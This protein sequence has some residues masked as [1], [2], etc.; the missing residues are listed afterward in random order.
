M[1]AWIIIIILVLLGI[2]ALQIGKVNEISSKLRGEDIVERENN[3]R[4]GFWLMVFLVAFLA[5]CFWSAYHYKNV[6]LGYGPLES[7]SEHG[8]LID[9]M[10]NVTLIFTGIVFV[11]TQILTFWYAYRYRRQEGVP[12]KFISHNNTLEL[13][14]TLVPSIVLT[15][16]VV[17]GLVAW[18]SIMPDVEEDENYIEVEATGYQFAWDLRLPGPDGKLGA[19]D[20]RLIN[21]ATNPLGLDWTDENA[22]D[23]IILGGADK[24]LLPKDTMVRVSIGSKDVLHNFFLPHFRVKMD[25]VPGMPT[26]FKFRPK[27]TTEE[28]RNKLSPYPEWNELSDPSD[29][30]SLPRWKAFNFELACAELCGKGHYSMKRIIEIVNPDV[31]ENWLSQQKSYFF[32]NVRGTEADPYTDKLFD[33]EIEQRAQELSTAINEALEA[34]DMTEQVISLD[35]VF[36]ETASAN[37]SE[38]SQ[39]ELDNLASIMK[40]NPGMTIEFRGHTDNV[41]DAESNMTLS[42]NRA[43]NVKSYLVGKGIEA[44]RMTAKGFGQMEPIDSNDTEAGREKNRR[45]EIRITSK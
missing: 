32:T 17:Q 41:G 40:D 3:D 9:S 19:K 45:T 36:Y 35:H 5:A 13:V 29:P 26:H 15:F 20:Y 16:L 28:Y 14:W 31:Y 6:M 23:D 7:A 10:F 37:L 11:I 27:F 4:Q 8:S 33:V 39:H 30:S 18:N 44:N 38:L 43:D 34:E 12:A 2:I 22:L 1:T 24:L 21:L 42:Q 25:A